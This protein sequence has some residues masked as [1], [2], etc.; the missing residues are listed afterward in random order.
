[1]I[2]ISGQMSKFAAILW[3][4]QFTYWWDD[5]VRFVLDQRA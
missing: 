4:K 5:D 3:R 1:V 2:V